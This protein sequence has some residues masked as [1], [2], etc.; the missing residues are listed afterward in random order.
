MLIPE[1]Q[2]LTNTIV[3]SISK[4]AVPVSVLRTDYNNFA[5][6]MLSVELLFYRDFMVFL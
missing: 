2:G 3:P 4:A 5:L 1:L 6:P